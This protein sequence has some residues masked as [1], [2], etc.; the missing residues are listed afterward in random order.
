MS[1]VTGRLTLMEAKEHGIKLL[2]VAV[3]YLDLLYLT[4]MYTLISLLAVMTWQE[5]IKSARN[6][7]AE[8]EDQQGASG[9]AGREE[10]RTQKQNW[11]KRTRNEETPLGG[12]TKHKKT[13]KKKQLNI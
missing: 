5:L 11:P 6:G 9:K 10:L 2:T 3:R 7:Q 8:E 13:K 4:L 12:E 1:Q